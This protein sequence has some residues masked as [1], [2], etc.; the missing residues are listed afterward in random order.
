[1]VPADPPTLRSTLQLA[2]DY[3][4][5]VLNS[6]QAA[7]GSMIGADAWCTTPDS[8]ATVEKQVR[9]YN[10]AEVRS[11]K[12]EAMDISGWVAYPPGAEAARISF[13]YQ[14]AANPGWTP[15]RIVVVTVQSTDTHARFICNVTN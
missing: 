9:D 11:Q 4:S 1:M 13:E 2:A 10:S 15:A 6:N 12:I 14:H 7:L 5:A 8:S 3:F